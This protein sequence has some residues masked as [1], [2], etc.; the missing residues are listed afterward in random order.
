MTSAFLSPFT[1]TISY[2]EH[3]NLLA[4]LAAILGGVGYSYC[5]TTAFSSVFTP[6]LSCFRLADPASTLGPLHAR[7]FTDSSLYSRFSYFFPWTCTTAAA[8]ISSPPAAHAHPNPLLFSKCFPI[9]SDSQ[10]LYQTSKHNDISAFICTTTPNVQQVIPSPL[11]Q[12][13]SIPLHSL[14]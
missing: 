2:S 11:S 8:T 4:R 7:F 12:L 10:R 14:P 5:A 13:T 3:T 6:L 9:Q 1:A